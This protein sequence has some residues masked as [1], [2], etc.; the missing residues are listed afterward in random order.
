VSDVLVVGTGLS[1]LA[2]AWYLADAGVRVEVV[3]AAPHPG[4]LIR[5]I[6]TPH[7]LVETAA[8]AFVR[9]PRVDALFAAL[10][11]TPCLPQPSSRRR[12]IFRDGRPRQWPLT[13][14]ETAATAAR[15]A[16][17]WMTRRV[18]ATDTETVDAWGRRVLGSAATDWLIAPAL[19]GI[20]ASSPAAL[21]AR[22]I[23]ASRPKGRRQSVS[24]PRGM[25]QCIERLHES[26]VKRGVAFRFNV[27]MT[28]DEIDPS[29][30]TVVATSAGAAA[31]LLARHAPRF[32]EAARRVRVAPI[33]TVTAFFEPRARDLH[34]FGV[35]F[36]R[37]TG[38]GAL[39][40]LFGADIF[41][42]RSALRS[43]TWIYAGAPNPDTLVTSMAADRERLT[44]VDA[45]PIAAYPT[46]WKEA[47][48]VY[49][50]AVLDVAAARSSL[51]PW[52]GVG[53]NYLGTIGVAGLLDIAAAAAEKVRC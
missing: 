34:G 27:A 10:D 25:G 24:P 37:G 1:G 32:A 26:L 51:P 40:V 44:G 39:G 50:D 45:R 2:T 49:N 8:N 43:E 16:R 13:P 11:L 19:H 5:T 15:F 3:D 48:P 36:P 38:V 4:G 46:V 21:N 47:I 6:S 12:F 52:L 20:Y 9:T 31:T 18:R 53:G 17:A 42:G 33:S 35:L 41:A 14:L 30:R 22:A 28:A 23:A 29:R 7:G